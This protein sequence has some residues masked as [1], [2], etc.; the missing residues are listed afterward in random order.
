ML[1]EALK[2]PI[3]STIGASIVFLVTLVCQATQK[4]LLAGNLDS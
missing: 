2:T 1:L 3:T 4:F